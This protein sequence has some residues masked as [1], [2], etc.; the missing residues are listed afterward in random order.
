M[1]RI[2]IVEDSPTQAL[3]LALIL[4]EAG[5]L[6][7]SVGTAEEGFERLTSGEFD[8]VISDLHLPGESG[9]DLC[10]R[11][12]ADPD[13]G[14]MPVMI[15]TTEDGPVN[16]FRGIEAG[17]DNF[18]TK[19]YNS[20]TLIARVQNVLRATERA[21]SAAPGEP[22]FIR[23]GKE[24][25][26]IQIE[27]GPI[28]GVL[29]SAFEDLTRASARLRESEAKVRHL[30]FYD[31]LTNLPN[32]RLALEKLG[33][34]L[35]SA[36][37]YERLTALLYLDL[38]GFKQINDSLGH[39]A[40]DQVLRE[41]AN[42]LTGCV[43]SSDLVVRSKR[44]APGEVADPVS[45][46][47][48]D[49]FMVLLPEIAQAQDAAA[50][51][52]RILE[53]LS[54]PI[55]IGHQE[56][57]VGASIG[58]AVYPLDGDEAA[59]L[60]KNADAAMYSVKESGRNGWK[61]FEQSMNESAV[62]KLAI[63]ALLRGA[64]ER[65][66]FALHYQPLRDTLSGNVIGAEALLRWANSERGSIAPAEF[67][68]IA[69]ETGLILPIGDWVIRS[70]CEQARAWQAAGYRPICIFVNVSARQFRQKGMAGSVARTL[71]ETG[72]SPAHL[73]LELIEIP[74]MRDEDATMATL[75]EL[76][77]MG[78]GFALDDFGSG[79]SS[80][81]YLRRFPFDRLKIDRSSVAEMTTNPEAAK[82]TMG[83]IGLG[84]CLGMNV[85]AKGVETV[86]QAKLL[87]EQGCDELQGYLF[88]PPVTAEKFVR[89]LEKEKDEPS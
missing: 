28:L 62:E 34:A 9:F 14:K 29:V 85:V 2:L 33:S 77:E 79:Y 84:H 76:K 35:A 64:L 38:D 69:E 67:I 54:M 37:R 8:L 16:V 80:F 88:S 39:G 20:E 65:G 59:T 23:F 31:S 61:F 27:R 74:L 24:E 58:I 45:R 81:S 71:Q 60:M 25:F 17:A 78:I 51:A 55:S 49:E 1:Q 40:G 12:K 75:R 47:G 32:R 36:K 48:G 5:F 66:E 50:V 13:H 43:R 70:A 73:G 19:E 52:G 11:I 42:R 30:A 83:I 18:M 87:R 6:A 68:P 57:S 86:E 7:E 41:T 21:R 26:K 15:I 53:R 72:L 46:L 3:Q 89:F 4:E 10:R 56:V 82:L 22:T 44:P 63:Q